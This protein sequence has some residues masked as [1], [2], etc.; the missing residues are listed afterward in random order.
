MTEVK[1]VGRRT[2]ILDNLRNGT[3]YW[4]VKEE[5]KIEKGENDCL[6][7]QHKEEIQIIFHASMDLLICCILYNNNNNLH[8]I[9]YKYISFSLK[10]ICQSNKYTKKDIFRDIKK[11]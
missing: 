3:R 10:N 7:I 8:G 6:S 9:W 5:A 2:Q 1:G 11:I 4:Q